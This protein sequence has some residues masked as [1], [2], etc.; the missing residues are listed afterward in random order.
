[1]TAPQK[2]SLQQRLD[3][4]GVICAE[5]YLFELERRGYLQAG[6]FVPEVA[7]EHPDV[8]EQVH[9]EFVRAGS[10]VVEA[11]TYNGHREKLRLVGKENLLEPLNR[12]ALRAAKRAAAQAE[13]PA[14]VAGNISNTNIYDP[15]DP[16]SAREVRA[17]FEEMVDWAVQEGVDFVIGETFYYLGEARL[18]L[19]VIRA[20]GLPAVVTFGLMGENVLRDGVSVEEGCRLLEQEGAAVVG[21]NCFRGP[22]TMLPY[23]KKIRAAV[24]CPVA[25]LPVPYRTTEKHPTFFNLED[26]GAD[27]ALPGGRTFPTALDPLYCNRYELAAFAREAYESGMRYLGVC[28]GATPVHIR[29][30]AEAIGRRPPASRYSPDMEKH[31]LYGSDERLRAHNTAYG[32]RA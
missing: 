15:D 31:F 32:A 5:G 14:L 4:G 9:R 1:M 12:S 26:P 29:T 24:S 25:A 2:R 3:D 17:M 6:S 13:E 19:E 21:M 16:T 23:L 8:L 18:A 7:L 10:D 22:A 27:G 20:A 11:F 30:V 28:C